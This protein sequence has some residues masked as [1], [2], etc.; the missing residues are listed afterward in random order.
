MPRGGISFLPG[1]VAE[2]RWLEVGEGVHA[3]FRIYFSADLNGWL[4][5]C[6][7]VG[8]DGGSGAAGSGGDGR[9]GIA[10]LSADTQ[11]RQ[12]VY[13]T[14]QLQSLKHTTTP[15]KLFAC[16]KDAPRREAQ[17]QAAHHLPRAGE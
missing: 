8:V 12:F 16:S 7:R 10:S 17:R 11:P 6:R 4:S 1:R 9:L 13:R 2:M 3:T 14:Q 5:C 15:L